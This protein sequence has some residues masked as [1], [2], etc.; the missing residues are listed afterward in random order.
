M[1]GTADSLLPSRL[2]KTIRVNIEGSW[3][4]RQGWNP[5]PTVPLTCPREHSPA[6]DWMVFA[7]KIRAKLTW[8]RSSSMPSESSGTTKRPG[9]TVIPA[10]QAFGAEIQD[11]D[12]RTIDSDDFS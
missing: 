6:C 12:L 7:A 5:Q 3:G 4:E 8:G 9:I 1:H 11:V 10:R 2:S